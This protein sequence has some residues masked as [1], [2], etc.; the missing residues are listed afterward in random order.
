MYQKFTCTLILIFF[1]FALFP[2]AYTQAIDS[3]LARFN[4]NT[5]QEKVY[6]QFDNSKY[7]PG[8]TIWYKA[9]L[10]SGFQ[11]STI[12]KNF[13]IDWYD[14]DGKLI[15]SQVTP[16]IYSYA[17]A[18]FKIPDSFIGSSIHA[19]AYTK[20]MRNFDSAYFFQKEFQI[21]SGKNIIEARSF[22]SKSS[23]IQFLPESGTLLS[24]RLNVVA[25]KA[26]N[27]LGLPENVTGIIRNSKGDSIVS[28]KSIHDGLGKF[29]FIPIS[30]EEYTAMWKDITSIIHK[31]TLP[32]SQDV[33]IN[34]SLEPGRSNRIFHVQRTK[35]VPESMKQL[36]L[37][38][39]MNGTI[40][41]MAKLNLTDKQAITSTLPI[42]KMLSGILQLTLFDSDEKPLCERIIFLKN[43]DYKLNANVKIDTLSTAKRGKNVIE[44]ELKDSTYSN[45]SLA[46]TDANTNE[47]SDDNIVS[48]LLLNGELS[49]NIYKPSYYFSS[50]ADSVSN[51]LDLVMLTNGWRRYNWKNI[52][53]NQITD[54]KFT[55]DSDYQNLNGIILEYSNKK[56]KKPETIN[57]IFVAKDSSNNMITLPIS[58]DGTFISRNAMLYDTTKIY[59]KLNGNTAL[60][61]KNIIIENNLFKTNPSI[62]Y[63]DLRSN[64]DTSGLSKLQYIIQEQA[65]L[66]S[67]N[68]HNTLNDVTVFTKQRSRIKELDKKFTFGVFSGEAAAAFDMSTLQNASHSID[69]YDF[70]DGK[71]PGLEFTSTEGGTMARKAEFRRGKASFYL[72][73]NYI[74]ETE[75]ANIDMSMVAYIK[76]FSPPGISGPNGSGGAIAIYTKKGVELNSKDF[77]AN[78]MDYKLYTGYVGY[79]EFYSPNYAEKSVVNNKDLRSTLLWDPWITLDK[80]NQKL[81]I[82]FYNNDISNAF[83]LVLEGMDSKGKL[84]SIH[85]Q[86]Q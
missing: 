12:S 30:G 28:F 43:D 31:N 69:V 59:F 55:R 1:L 19:I 78:G 29:Q 39:Q 79:K 21:V 20:W 42:N 66:D 50:N 70:L 77:I 47:I 76:V 27:G 45:F 6:L 73:E 63:N 34:L 33:G 83:R 38:G 9:Y 4:E 67:I 84:V 58:D 26:I 22:S 8:Q 51:H 80:S 32:I 25:F 65:K 64:Y 35:E 49:G 48:H 13:Y 60:N 15:S 24:N 57:L 61:N 46:I 2:N 44:I 72:N 82:T 53:E 16:V 86:L 37:V 75:A 10:M 18:N 23:S 71:V 54:L 56:S 14:N 62:I 52:L 7:A 40:L 41:F 68:K 74:N 17:A 11:P 36:I 5:P 85:K 3:A 81:K